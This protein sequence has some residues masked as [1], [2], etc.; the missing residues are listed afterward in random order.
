MYIIVML[1]G[2]TVVGVIQPNWK[3]VMNAPNALLIFI[4]KIII[5][6]GSRIYLYKVIHIAKLWRGA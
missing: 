1:Y 3:N 6:S 2:I 5:K 4:M